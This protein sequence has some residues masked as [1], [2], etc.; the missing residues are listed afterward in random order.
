M[1]K[2]KHR[3]CLL[4]GKGLCAGDKSWLGQITNL[5]DKINS[6]MDK[7]KGAV[8]TMFTN[9]TN[10]GLTDIQKSVRFI[11]YNSRKNKFLFRIL[12]IGL[13]KVIWLNYLIVPINLNFNLDLVV[14]VRLRNEIIF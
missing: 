6:I 7:A 12:V 4:M 5:A 8:T 9:S 13:Q 3:G 10:N 11:K 14:K 2:D 1:T